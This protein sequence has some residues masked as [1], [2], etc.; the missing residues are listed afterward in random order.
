[1]TVERMLSPLRAIVPRP[2]TRLEP[3]SVAAIDLGSNSF[4]MIVARAGN[5][6]VHVLDR[7][8]EMVR[9]ASGLDARCHLDKSSRLRALDCLHRFGERLRGMP[10]GSVRAVGTDTLRRARNAKKFL[11]AAERALGHPIEVISGQEEARV[12]YQGVAH[13]LADDAEPRLIIDIGGGSTE[14][15]VGQRL[16]TRLA[17][18][19]HMGCVAYSKK[20]FARGRVT[21]DA[22]KRA[23]TAAQLELQPVE[24]AF[25]AAGWRA[26][27]GTSG[28]IR[29]AG[30]VARAHGWTKGE[31][32]P[33]ALEKL[34]EALLGTGN[35]TR[36]PF[37]GLN[38]D[39]APIFPGGVVIL[40]AMF[41]ALGIER[42]EVAN[43]ALREGLLYNLLGR[44]RHTDAR[45]RTIAALTARYRLDA[46]QAERVQ[47]TAARCF[48]EVTDAWE[49]DEADGQA[50][51]WAS[52]LHELGLT[53]AHTKYHRHGAYLV[54]HSDLPGFSREEQALLATLI[55]SHRRRFPLSVF[56]DLPKRERRKAKRLTVLLRLAVLLHRGRTSIDLP[57][58]RLDARARR[59]RVQF[60]R[61]WL[62]KNPLTCADLAREA[63]YLSAAKY[64]LVCR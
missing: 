5:G 13:D 31:I 49:L 8:Q 26:V 48:E 50:L 18:S 24:K 9:L 64:S 6:D 62:R 41:E 12:I 1:M 23:A 53:I 27:Y 47:Q 42:M 55:R 16:E 21:A 34:R 17:E 43:G 3:Q 61:G 20:Y 29:T 40:A 22:W 25:R 30:A 37:N 59:L 33:A 32:T 11:A 28:T 56:E 36:V 15:I 39:R 10:R 57:S 54:A 44:I 45:D 14:L 63:Y 38:P 7:L 35:L 2:R 58:I 60:P 51:S 19:L 52:R 4:H 46:A